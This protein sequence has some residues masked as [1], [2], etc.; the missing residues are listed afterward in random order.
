M[1]DVPAAGL[2]RTHYAPQ[3]EHCQKDKRN[4]AIYPIKGVDWRCVNRQCKGAV[5]HRDEAC[6]THKPL[7]FPRAQLV[8][9]EVSCEFLPFIE[10]KA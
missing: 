8:R 7:F 10:E 2:V 9:Q 4:F 3:C 1:F 6:V 5:V